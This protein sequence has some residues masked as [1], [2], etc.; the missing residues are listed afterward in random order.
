[1]LRARSTLRRILI[2]HVMAVAVIAVVLPA[3]LYFLLQSATG[4]LHLRAMAQ[5]A[6]SLSFFL[7]PGRDDAGAKWRFALPETINDLYSEQYGRYWYAIADEQGQVL[8]TS[9]K[10]SSLTLGPGRVDG[11]RE[12]RGR[13]GN[14]DVSG[15]SVTIERF[16]AKFQVQVAED[17]AHSDV[18]IDDIVKEFFPRVGWVILPLLIVLLLIDAVIFRRALEPLTLASEQA[19]SITPQL[20]S[21]RIDAANIPSEVLPLVS[22]FNNALERLEAGY[23]VQR[24]FSAD[25]AHELRTPLA[26]LRSKIEALKDSA[27]AQDLLASVDNMS[28]VVTQLLH[29]T[30]AEQFAL[31]ESETAD[32]N[33]AAERVVAMLAP[34]A[35]DRDREIALFGP[36]K[37]VW[38]HGHATLIFRVLRNLT[39]NAL[40][41]A[42]QGSAVEIRLSEDGVI[43]VSDQGPGIRDDEKELVFQRFWR[44]DRQAA[45]NTGLGLSIVKRIADLHGASLA[46]EDV[47]PHGAR[48]TL[49]F[50]RAEHAPPVR[51]E[52]ANSDLNV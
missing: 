38:V 39:E 37:P 42:P 22:A 29:L 45:G 18:I 20:A 5:L 31:D 50:R 41:Y 27:G 30:E 7:T 25:A 1:M 11:V 10:L 48:I 36:E 6:E 28:H 26:V 2:L 19:R 23:K 9:A 13:K 24:E 51:P 14:V 47:E 49:T 17:L 40:R 43:S 15:A 52:P 12:L 3:S 32:L 21:I 8:F 4:T 33:D 35:I 44:R 46:I 34:L 16:G